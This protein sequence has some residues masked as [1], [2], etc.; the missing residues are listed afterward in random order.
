MGINKIPQFCASDNVQ[1]PVHMMIMYW[2]MCTSASD[3]M[4]NTHSGI[5]IS[6][7]SLYMHQHCIAAMPVV[8]QKSNTHD[9]ADAQRDGRVGGAGCNTR[10]MH[11]H[12]R[13]TIRLNHYSASLLC[14]SFTNR[15]RPQKSLRLSEC[16]TPRRMDSSDPGASHRSNSAG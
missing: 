6:H 12:L 13:M 3:D 15:S 7:F 9:H 14:T 5:M 16:S 8:K 4:C 2:D 10:H 1:L 11:E